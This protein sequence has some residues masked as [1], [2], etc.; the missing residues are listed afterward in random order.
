ME[1]ANAANHKPHKRNFLY[2][3]FLI[4]ICALEGQQSLERK[5]TDEERLQLVKIAEDPQAELPTR[6]GAVRSLAS[7]GGASAHD[8]L[9]ELLRRTRSTAKPLKNWDPQAAER[10]VDL[11]IVLGLHRFGDDSEIG[12]IAAV[13]RQAGDILL[14]RENELYNAAQVIL[15]IGRKEPIGEVVA[16]TSDASPQAVRN[17]VKLLDS[18]NLP[19]PPAAHGAGSIPRLAEKVSFTARNVAEE[20][21]KMASL[22]GG[23]VVLSNGVGEFMHRHD[24]RGQVRREGVPLSQVLEQ[25]L[26]VLGLDYFVEGERVV[27]CTYQEAGLRWRDWWR[28]YS[29]KLQYV[30]GT[31]RFVLSSGT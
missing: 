24:N 19:D 29:G 31:S 25:H 14:G 8:S 13:V 26:P 4:L 3:P 2:A 12:R 23:S 10:V 9:K 5:M 21:E 30:A 18:L 7:A 27:I 11:Q 28:K 1:R 17:A 6:V 15:A 16:L 20:L 22:S